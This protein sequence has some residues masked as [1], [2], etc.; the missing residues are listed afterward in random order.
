VKDTPP[1]R[2]EKEEAVRP[3]PKVVIAKVIELMG[4]HDAA[5]EKFDRDYAEVVR[6][7]DQDTD[8]VGRILRAHLFVE[9]FLTE[10]LEARAPELEIKNAALTFSKKLA[11]VGI[12]DPG[13]AYLLPGIRLVNTIRNRI[14]H[15]LTAD[16]TEDDARQLLSIDVFR[17]MRAESDRRHGRSLNDDPVD[18]VERFCKHAG[19]ALQ[20]CTSPERSPWSVAIEHATAEARSDHR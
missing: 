17:A 13:V 12:G 9:H 2:K 6:V 4:G 14:A 7:W 1:A 15:R 8:K 18:V 20:A 3:D 5:F 11:L 19:M 10:Y 16:V